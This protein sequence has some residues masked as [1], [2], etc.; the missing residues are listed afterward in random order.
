MTGLKRV[1]SEISVPATDLQQS[2]KSGDDRERN[3]MEA[4]V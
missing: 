1:A 4:R 3:E 2:S